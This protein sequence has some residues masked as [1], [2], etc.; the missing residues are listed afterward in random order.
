MGEIIKVGRGV[1]LYMEWVH[2]ADGPGN[3]GTRAEFLAE[4]PARF[5]EC[6]NCD[7]NTPEARMARADETG[8]DYRGDIATTWDVTGIV[9][10]SPVMGW[11]PRARFE[12]FA[13]AATAGGNSDLVLADYAAME[14]LLDPF[15]RT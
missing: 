11:L 8:S 6:P 9:V 12:A 10:M 1:D 3:I 15:D 13:R 14:A 7:C 4:L 5:H 2:T